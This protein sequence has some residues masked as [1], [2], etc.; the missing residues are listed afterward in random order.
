MHRTEHY[1]TSPAGPRRVTPAGQLQEDEERMA[2]LARGQL[3]ARTRAERAASGKPFGLSNPR[4]Q[5]ALERWDRASGLV[6]AAAAR[7]AEAVT[8]APTARTREQILEEMEHRAFA[9][10]PGKPFDAFLRTPEGA[11]LYAEYV[12]AGA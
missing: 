11:R 7:A 10:M 9:T 2:V 8:A 12:R 1:P 3:L 5:A 4:D 6:Q